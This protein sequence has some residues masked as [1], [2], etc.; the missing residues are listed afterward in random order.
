MAAAALGATGAPAPRAG[1]HPGWNV[2][3]ADHVRIVV[4]VGD[5][6]R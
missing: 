1:G 4:D 5:E 3:D 6:P 2:V